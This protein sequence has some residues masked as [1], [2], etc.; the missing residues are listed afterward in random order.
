MAYKNKEDMVRANRERYLRIKNEAWYLEKKRDWYLA[1]AKRISEESKA[2][3]A[4]HPRI[5]K[6]EEEKRAT[7]K[8][9]EEANREKLNAS[10]AKRRSNNLERYR[11]YARGYYRDKLSFKVQYSRLI[12]SSKHRK[13]EVKVSLEEFIEIVSKP[14]IYC[15]E[16][17]ERRGIDRIDNTTA[18]L[19]E[20]SASCCKI[21]NYMKKTMTVQEFLDHIK[22]I[23][24]HNA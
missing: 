16:K 13:I 24:I 2:K 14:C 8:K 17:D 7:R 1:N 9:W 21:C 20:N 10:E 18:Y 15:G 11:L 6:T 19:K 5:L 22:K 4:L 3:R 12:H 23:S